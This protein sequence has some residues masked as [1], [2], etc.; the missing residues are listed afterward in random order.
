VD[1]QVATLLPPHSEK[2]LVH[3]RSRNTNTSTTGRSVEFLVLMK[4]LKIT[5]FLSSYMR[6]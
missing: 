6:T 2:R 1:R 5:L 3:K 4:T